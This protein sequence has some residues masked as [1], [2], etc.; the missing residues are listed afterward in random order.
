MIPSSYSL[1]A[2]KRVLPR[3]ALEFTTGALDPRVNV[4]RALNTDTIVNNS[5]L[6]EILQTGSATSLVGGGFEPVCK[7]NHCGQ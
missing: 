4:T 5:G 3:L 6:T 7:R 1:T 2:T